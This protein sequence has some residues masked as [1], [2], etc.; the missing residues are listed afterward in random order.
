MGMHI[1]QHNDNYIIFCVVRPVIDIAW[2]GSQGHVEHLVRPNRLPC[3]IW[4]RSEH[5]NVV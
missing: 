5:Q 1:K 3:S 2:H 4:R